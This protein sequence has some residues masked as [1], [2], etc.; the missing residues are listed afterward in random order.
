MSKKKIFGQNRVQM[1]LLGVLLST[2]F[3][4]VNGFCAAKTPSPAYTEKDKTFTGTVTP[5]LSALVRYGYNDTDRGIVT[6]T[7][8]PGQF[9][10]GPILDAKGNVIKK[11]D[12]LITLASSYHK[13]QLDA[14][15]AQLKQAEAQMDYATINNNRATQLLKTP[16][17]IAQKVIDD[18][19]ATYEES[20]AG[21]EAAKQALIT[22]KTLYALIH[23]R[24][25]FDGVVTKVYMASGLLN[26]EPPVLQLA[27][28]NPMGIKI[29]LDHS[30]AKKLNNIN[31]T[32][33][34]YPVRG[35]NKATG[36]LFN[37]TKLTDDG[38]MLA[39]ENYLISPKLEKPNT[40]VVNNTQPVLRLYTL[41][42]AAKPLAVPIVSLAKDNQG[43]YVWQLVGNK[44]VQAGKGLSNIYKAKKVYVKPGQLIK[45]INNHIHYRVLDSS[46]NLS[47]YDLVLVIDNLPTNLKDNAEVCLAENKYLFMPGDKVK[48]EVN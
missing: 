23:E 11:G 5:I 10:Y 9:V 16:G 17:V 15:K 20:T 36:I 13:E 37:M 29:K 46:G 6:Y 26:N 25:V 45:K 30:I 1:C 22:A 48:I 38:I 42:N 2:L 4:S 19:I 33:T 7:T 47:Q 12:L 40:P 41:G 31:N 24:A 43:S 35:D 32:I 14:A 21:L 27:A 18:Y 39:V 8:L 3:L 28:L 44:E 34:V